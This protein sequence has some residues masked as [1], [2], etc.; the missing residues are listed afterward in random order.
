[1]RRKARLAEWLE[2]TRAFAVLRALPDLAGHQL[3]VLN[4]HR[5]FDVP[6]DGTF[7]FDRGLISATPTQFREQMAHA[8]SHYDPIRFADL[9]NWMEGH[10]KLPKRPLLITFDDGHADNYTHAFPILREFDI[11][12]AIFLST[13]YIDSGELFWFESVAHTIMEA[14]PGRYR[15]PGNFEPMDISDAE[16]RRKAI[17]RV[18]AH[19]KTL[20]DAARVAV[21]SGLKTLMV[22][23]APEHAT[24]A[25]A[26]TWDQIREMAQQG[27]EFGSH[28]VSHPILTKLDDKTLAHELTS[29]LQTIKRELGTCLDVLAY[30]EGSTSAF[31]ARVVDATR[32]AGY[33]LGLS[34]VSG[35]NILRK[36]DPFRVKRLH[37]DTSIPAIQFRAL[38]AMPRL[39]SL[40]LSRPHAQGHHAT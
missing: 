10:S 11:P 14:K 12:A 19:I 33:R 2:R 3:R 18:L 24:M 40:E 31:N 17:E 8:K 29:S 20:D 22:P 1:M 7:T 38:L 23:G 6:N 37:I 13:Q 30:P 5:V 9:L 25:G 32:R 15:L 4:Y 21:V 16:S 27:I 36:F 34:Y 26:L 35:T 28:S 39:F